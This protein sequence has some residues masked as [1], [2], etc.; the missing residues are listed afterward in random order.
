MG[1]DLTIHVM[2]GVKIPDLQRFFAH[3][4]GSKWFKLGYGNYDSTLS[5]KMYNTPHIELGEL[6]NLKAMLS[7]DSDTYIPSALGEIERII[8]ENLPVINDEL[9]SKIGDAMD[10]ENKTR[11]RLYVT[12]D[13]VIEFL[14]QHRGKQVFTICW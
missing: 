14:D 3:T 4:L 6:S 10:L 9:I 12:K 7:D 8:G 5:D 2:E 13:E 1:A 11:Y